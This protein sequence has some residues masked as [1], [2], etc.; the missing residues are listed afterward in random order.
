MVLGN[1]TGWPATKVTTY[2]EAKYY[3]SQIFKSFLQA[4]VR[5]TNVID[6]SF[7]AL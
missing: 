4:T 1:V 3:V 2:T 7:A 5:N 6:S